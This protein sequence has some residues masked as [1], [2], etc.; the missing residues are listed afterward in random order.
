[1]VEVKGYSKGNAKASDLLQ[2]GAAVETFIRREH[3]VP[4]ARWYVVNQ[5]FDTA[6]DQRLRPLGGSPDLDTFAN[7]G[8]LVI[9]TTDLFQLR[10]SVRAND[11][12]PSEARS[13]LRAATGVLEYPPNGPPSR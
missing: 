2:L 11:I 9:S 3:Q 4:D 6:P 5:S 13:L 8:G 12:S 1:M 10:E 7:L